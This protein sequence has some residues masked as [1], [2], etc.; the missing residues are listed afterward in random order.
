MTSGNC[1]TEPSG[2]PLPPTIRFAFRL[3][4]T[5]SPPPS[6]YSTRFRSSSAVM[7]EPTNSW[8]RPA[9]PAA[10]PSGFRFPYVI[11]H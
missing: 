1:S 10:R 3:N 8:G 5:G 9:F 6:V 2:I 7:P 11:G 4:G